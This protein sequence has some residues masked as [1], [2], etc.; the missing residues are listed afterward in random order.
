MV[1]AL[2]IFLKRLYQ[3]RIVEKKVQ[4]REQ[5]KV[6]ELIKQLIDDDDDD[7]NIAQVYYSP[8]NGVLAPSLFY[9]TLLFSYF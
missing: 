1:S 9:C 4:N 2:F 6:I 3:I 8:E 7:D 5:T